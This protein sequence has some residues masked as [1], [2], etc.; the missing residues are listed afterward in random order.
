V[1]VDYPGLLEEKLPSGEMRYRVRPKGDFK[2]RITIYCGPKDDDFLRQYQLA[3]AG[4]KPEPIKKASEVAM[5]K[6][7][8]WLVNSYLEYLEERIKSG[9]FSA[10]T[11]KKKRNLLIKLLDDPERKML[12][13]QEK[14]IE[15]QDKMVATPAQADAFIEAVGV[16]YDWAIARKYVKS[17]PARGI[18][19]I[20]EKGDGA[21]PWQAADVDAFFAKHKIGSKAHVCMSVL[22]WTGC[23]I[24]DTTM[25]GRQHERLIDGVEALQW[26]PM[27]K[28]STEVAI[29]L[30]PALKE[31]TRAPRVQG[32]TYVLGRGGKP[33]ASGDSASAMFKRWCKDAG[34]GHLSAHGVRKGLAELLAHLGCSQYEIMAIL[35]HSE[36]KTSEVYTRRVERWR[37]ALGAMNR[38]NASGSW[39]K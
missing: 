4:D 5:A 28:H 26:T 1:K 18:E 21:T 22:L 39:S 23:R 37:L 7:I 36:A 3:R 19:K 6:S 31:A 27:K 16:M 20:Y 9:N 10:K 30:F 25:L 11:L 33:F 24:E 34:I 17:N 15:R 29:P 13:P 38:V 12:I 8:G 35:G 14:L 32:K 2:T